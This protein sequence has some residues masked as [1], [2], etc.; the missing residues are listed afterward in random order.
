VNPGDTVTWAFADTTQAH[1][2]MQD[3]A[4]VDVPE[5]TAFHTT[6][7]LA[8][9]SV[10]FTFQ[11]DGT[12]KFV[13]ELHRATMFGTVIVGSGGPIIVVPASQQVFLNDT[14]APTTLE[15]V[16]EDKAAP[17]LASVSARRVARGAVRVRYRV[18]EQSVVDVRLK[19]AGRTVKT[20]SNAGTG[21][22][23]VTLSSLKAG[24]YSIEVRATDIAGNHSSLR[25]L[26]LTVR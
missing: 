3:G 22:R 18:S 25:R 12:Y 15:L 19:R 20:G 10:P 13:C 7:A 24:R 26:S 4:N 1:N 9:P 2:V 23:G 21:T 17:K 6:P 5:W 8:P 14:P 11:T 16:S